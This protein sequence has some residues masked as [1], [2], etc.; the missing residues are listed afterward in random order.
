MRERGVVIDGPDPK[1][2]IGPISPAE[3]REA[4]RGELKERLRGWSDGSWPAEEM[5]HRGAQ[6]FEIETV[7]RALQTIETAE[8][9]TKAQAVAWALDTLPGRW[10]SLIEWSQALRGDRTRDETK[11]AEVMSF[12]R[13]AVSEVRG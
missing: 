12:L 1:T 8:L 4:V 10:R 2:L 6:A 3:I 11:V 7:C 5:T 9:M 13:W